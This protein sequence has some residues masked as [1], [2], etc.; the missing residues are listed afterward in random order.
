MSIRVECPSCR[1]V[2]SAPDEA[3][4][5][6]DHCPSCRTPV[7][8]TRPLPSSRQS[9]PRADGFVICPNPNCGYKG[10]AKKTRRGSVVVMLILLCFWILPGIIYAFG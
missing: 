6:E 9:T 3:E 7:S 2:F 10:P 8:V 5:R 4:G 1:K